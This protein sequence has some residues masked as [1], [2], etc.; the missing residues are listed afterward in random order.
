MA[1]AMGATK[2]I[3]IVDK[4]IRAIYDRTA[5]KL[6]DF[7]DMINAVRTI[8]THADNQDQLVALIKLKTTNGAKKVIVEATTVTEIVQR[9]QAKCKGKTPDQI[10][11]VMADVQY[12]G[13]DTI[14]LSRIKKS[15]R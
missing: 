8:V 11:T 13:T 6:G 7:V 4:L 1:V 2:L 5:G 12:L 15:T 3:D 9:L 10:K 14:N